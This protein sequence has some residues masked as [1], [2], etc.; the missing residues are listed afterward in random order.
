MTVG[1]LIEKLK[2]VD[3]E[4]KV[5]FYGYNEPTDVSVT[6]SP[7]YGDNSEVCYIDGDIH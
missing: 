4:L 6:K 2:S 5:V 7:F 1:E 3:P